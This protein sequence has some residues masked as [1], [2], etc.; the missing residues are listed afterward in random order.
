[1]LLSQLENLQ[2][3]IKRAIEQGYK[4]DLLLAGIPVDDVSLH[5][6][7][8]AALNPRED[9]EAEL[10]KV[11][12]VGMKID[13]GLINPDDGARELGYEKAADITFP[14]DRGIEENE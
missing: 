13:Y 2:M 5:F 14:K 8:L 11:E 3:I 12:T 6:N 4:L 1:M 9:A 7:P 10:I